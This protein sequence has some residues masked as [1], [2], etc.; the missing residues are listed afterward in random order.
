MYNNIFY[1]E[2]VNVRNRDV[3]NLAT[4]RGI[5]TFTLKLIVKFDS[6]QC[7]ITLKLVVKFNSS[8]CA[9]TSAKNLQSR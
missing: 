7:A 9:S 8:Q 2:N 6:T 5:G 3:Q 4:C 1:V